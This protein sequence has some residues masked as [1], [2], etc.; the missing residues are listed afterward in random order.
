MLGAPA[1]WEIIENYNYKKRK[2]YNL[3]SCVSLLLIFIY[4][5]CAIFDHEI[6]IENRIKV[7]PFSPFDGTYLFFTN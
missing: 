7:F 1:L 2:K 4:K 5:F 3:I 6:Q